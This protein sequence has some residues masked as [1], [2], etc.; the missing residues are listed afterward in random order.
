M[1]T[2]VFTSRT[3]W[4]EAPRLRHQ[5]AECLAPHFRIV[6]VEL[7][8]AWAGH[9]LRRPG[10]RLLHRDFEIVTFGNALLPPERIWAVSAPLRRVLRQ[11]WTR[12]VE[13]LAQRGA[14][15]VIVL[16]FTHDHP[17]LMG[18][19]AFDASV[20]VCSDD[21][22]AQ[23]RPW[24][25][26]EAQLLERETAARAG[27]CLAVSYPLQERLRAV[28]PWTRLLL[29]GHSFGAEVPYWSKPRP[30]YVLVFMG[31]L[32]YRVDTAWLATLL[33]DE[34]WEVRLIGK[35][36]RSFDDIRG[37][38]ATGRCRLLGELRGSELFQAMSEANV[39]AMP[40]RL[41]AG[42]PAATA[43][44]KLFAYLATGRPVVSSALP[45]LLELP[46]QL[47][48]TAGTAAEFVDRVRAAVA[49][50]SEARF[51]ERIAFAALHTW[52]GKALG[53]KREL[54]GLLRRS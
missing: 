29:P 20:Y 38:L 3:R 41:T 21:W 19:P 47:L 18:S 52:E 42:T 44:N 39:L 34:A 26:P 48:A 43:P 17:G 50:D 9:G 32:D 16:N 8:N 4:E 54:E 7:P 12:R 24:L 27:L 15:R 37:L 31:Y 14:G 45:R 6:F 33:R 51:R 2:L 30:P 25:R 22:V 53:L 49:S 46:A 36:Q 35:P 13:R 40:Y 5:L 11:A 28:N 23:A 10:R 1:D